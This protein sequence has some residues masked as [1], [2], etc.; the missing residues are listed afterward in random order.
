MRDADLI[1]KEKQ[2]RSTAAFHNRALRS[3]RPGSLAYAAKNRLLAGLQANLAKLQGEL[4]RRG[5]LVI[6]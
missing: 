1:R 4:E 2:L 6:Y 3:L 5:F